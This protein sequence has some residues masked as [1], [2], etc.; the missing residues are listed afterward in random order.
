MTADHDP[1]KGAAVGQGPS[2]AGG[3]SARPG[4]AE[5]RNLPGADAQEA[6]ITGLPV[7]AVVL[8][9]GLSR[10]MGSANKL[11]E[12]V[13]GQAM[14][15]SVVEQVVSAAVAEVVVVLGHES[16]T[17]IQ[18]LAGLPVEFVHNPHYEEGLGTS[19][20]T[21]IAAVKPQHAALVCLGDMPLVSAD[22]ISALVSAYRRRPELMAYR[23]SFQGKPGN[24][25]LWSS[26]SLALLSTLE[27]DEGARRLLKER[28]HE[29]FA[30]PVSSSGVLLDIDTPDQLAAIRASRSL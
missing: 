9:A 7:T 21:G 5:G 18:A 14:V 12:E 26:W 8:A 22:V 23:P 4:A 17:I 6:Q 30:V 16:E 1:R 28:E 2:E 11:L 19:V 3:M 20:R 10:R 25:V 15:R 24:P 29:V 27:G 13:H